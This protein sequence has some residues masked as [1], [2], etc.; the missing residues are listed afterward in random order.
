MV[1]AFFDCCRVPIMNQS[2]ALGAVCGLPKVPKENKPTEP[3][4]EEEKGDEE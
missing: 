2:A 3:K 4:K 1:S